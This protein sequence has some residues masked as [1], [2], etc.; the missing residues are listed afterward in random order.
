MEYT[1]ESVACLG[2]CALS[3]C[4][5]VDGKVHGKLNPKKAKEVIED[6]RGH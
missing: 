6:A 3:P 2:C 4:M 1:L 5:M